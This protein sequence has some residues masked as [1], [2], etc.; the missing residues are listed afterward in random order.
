[1][2][3]PPAIQTKQF[4]VAACCDGDYRV[5]W[6]LLAYD[7]PNSANHFLKRIIILQK[8]PADIIRFSI[9]FVSLDKIPRCT[10][11]SKRSML[12][13]RNIARRIGAVLS[14]FCTYLILGIDRKVTCGAE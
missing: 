5:G 12:H 13:Y 1:M 7:F 9:P 2:P 4:A 6:E 3:G 11:S 8:P 10:V 14:M